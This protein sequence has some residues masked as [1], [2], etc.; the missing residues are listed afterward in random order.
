MTAGALG[1]W[2]TPHISCSLCPAV[3]SIRVV[4]T[5]GLQVAWF[6]EWFPIISC[7]LGRERRVA[8]GSG[9]C[10]QDTLVLVVSFVSL[11][12]LVTHRLPWQVLF[13]VFTGRD[14]FW[15]GGDDVCDFGRS[16]VWNNNDEE[17]PSSWYYRWGWWVC[18]GLLFL[19]LHV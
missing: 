12:S 7:I 18:N 4:L 1:S 6:S 8:V 11:A 14:G 13:L 3:L 19:E 10:W 2:G 15:T 5:G 16:E 17:T 9:Q